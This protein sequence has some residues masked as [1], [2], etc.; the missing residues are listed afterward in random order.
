VTHR[1]P[2][3]LPGGQAV[4]YT[5]ASQTGN[6]VEANIVAERIPNGERKTLW[7]GSYF[8]RYLPSGHIV[9]VR[10]ATLFA[11]RF[12]L[13]TLEMT[14]EPIPVLEGVASSL[15]NASVQLSFSNKWTLV[16]LPGALTENHWTLEWMDGE[17]KRRPLLA[18]AAFF[19][20]FQISPDGHRLALEIRDGGKDDIWIYEW[21][22]DT[23]SRLTFDGTQNENPVWSPDG[24]AIAF[25][26]GTGR[27]RKHLLEKGGW[28]RRNPQTDGR[29]QHSG[30]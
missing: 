1:W 8:A 12:D 17:G 10:E 7:Q 18:E 21:E 13:E 27:S 28:Q 2:Q 9:Y 24:G 22:R 15:S 11:A 29:L 30:A 23:L 20:H 6:Y 14:D 4:L 5:A 19:D 26:L 25:L 3:V 16:Y